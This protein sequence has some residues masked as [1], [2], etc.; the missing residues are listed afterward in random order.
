MRRENE[1]MNI[2]YDDWA[3][4]NTSKQKPI[5]KGRKSQDT[6]AQ[7]NENYMNIAADFKFNLRKW[8]RHENEASD[9]E[10]AW[11]MAWHKDCK[12]RA[13]H[14]PVDHCNW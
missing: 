13:C 9:L 14:R 7:Q 4:I 12:A 5:E 6:K 1:Y 11:V 8:R 3:I 2:M 10:C